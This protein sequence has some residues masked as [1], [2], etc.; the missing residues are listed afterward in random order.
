MEQYLSKKVAMHTG[1]RFCAQRRIQR[2]ED[3]ATVYELGI[4]R[5]DSRWERLRVL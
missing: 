1:L 2:S 5:H 4:D 3:I